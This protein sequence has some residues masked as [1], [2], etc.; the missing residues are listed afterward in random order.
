MERILE[1]LEH[2]P[3]LHAAD[4]GEAVVTTTIVQIDRSAILGLRLGLGRIYLFA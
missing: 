4:W 2:T 1:I 3:T